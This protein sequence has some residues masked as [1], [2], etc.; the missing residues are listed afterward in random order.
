MFVQG[1]G[2]SLNLN[3]KQ[4]DTAKH[5]VHSSSSVKDSMYSDASHETAVHDTDR[6]ELLLSIKGKIRSGFYTSDSVLE[7]L[8][9]GFAKIFDKTM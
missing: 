9:H 8:S 2:H 3:S 5:K 7:D 4:N 6:K 1:L